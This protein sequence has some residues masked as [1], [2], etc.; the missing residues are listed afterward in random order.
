MGLASREFNM[1]LEQSQRRAATTSVRGPAASCRAGLHPPRA[2]TVAALAP[3]LGMALFSAGHAGNPLPPAVGSAQETCSQLQQ[4][5]TRLEADK[6][7]MP[8]A[9]TRNDAMVVDCE[10]KRVE[11]R[12][13]ALL[14][15]TDLTNQWHRERQRQHNQLVCDGSA[16][17]SLVEQKWQVVMHITT[18]DDRQIVFLARC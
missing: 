18:A 14:T 13:R 3:W 17:R 1:S 15:S 12:K 5:A 11:F 10:A 6:G 9:V 16:F 4:L 8:D 7:S 2:R